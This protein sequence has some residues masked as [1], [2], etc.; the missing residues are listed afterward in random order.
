LNS[1]MGAV[2]ARTLTFEEWKAKLLLEIIDHPAH[3]DAVYAL[4]E[5]ALYALYEQGARPSL[6][7]L[8]KHCT[9]NWDRNFD[10]DQNL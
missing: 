6:Q 7:G 3:I 8:L 2:S 9:W 5:H 4:S 1:I 10:E